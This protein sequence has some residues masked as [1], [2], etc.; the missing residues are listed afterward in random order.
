MGAPEETYFTPVV[1]MDF[2]YNYRVG[3]YITR[4]LDG[5]KEKK[6]LGSKCP[7]CSLVAVPPRKYCGVC[8][9]VMEEMVELGQE[10]T[11][12]E[13]HRGPRGPGEGQ[14]EPRRHPLRPRDDQAGGSHLAAPGQGGGR[15]PRRGQDG[16]EGKGG[17]EGPGE[18]GTTTTSTTSSRYKGVKRMDKNVAI[19]GY[20][21]QSAPDLVT[22]R[23][24]LVFEL[25]RGLFD[26]LGI[27][28]TDVDTTIIDSN[29]FLDGRTI[30]NV[31]LD[32]PA[33]V[34]MQD[35]SKVEMDAINAVIYAVH[36]HPL[37]AV[38]HG[39]GREPGAYRI[40][41]Q[42]LP[43]HRVH[44]QPHLRPPGQTAQRDQ[45]RRL[46]GA[47]LPGQVR[48]LRGVAGR[49]RGPGPGQRGPQSQPVPPH[50]RHR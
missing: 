47:Q 13:L 41:G 30:S 50:L 32:P 38:Q 45:C 9:K 11:A 44:P 4:Y 3:P 24:R 1:P 10:G 8:N 37:R 7:G 14:A 2:T 29:D 46:P 49:H 15:E 25:T 17:L 23:E 40:P 26:D 6:I 20:R 31:F 36:A 18:P 22:S 16:H 27:E 42:P 39:P 5:F 34:Y 35:E 28:R 33:G 21:T 19:V 12:G 48:L 43:A